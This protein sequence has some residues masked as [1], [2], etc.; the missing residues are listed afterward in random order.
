MIKDLLFFFITAFLAALLMTMLVNFA[1]A[2]QRMI[3]GSD[4]RVIGRAATDSRG[5]TTLYGADGRAAIRESPV[6]GGSTLY[7]AKS[8]RLIGT[9]RIPGKGKP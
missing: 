4:G 6:T 2:E 8:G 7:E 1:K 9:T 3:Y 5:N